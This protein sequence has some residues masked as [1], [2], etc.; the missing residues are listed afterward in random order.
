M[1]KT[2]LTPPS[3]VGGDGLKVVSGVDMPMPLAADDGLY[4]VV[5]PQSPKNLDLPGIDGLGWWASR[6]WRD[7]LVKFDKNNGEPLWAVGRRAPGLAEPGQM[8]CPVSVSGKSGD[9]IFVADALSVVWVWHADGLYIGRLFRDHHAGLSDVPVDQ[10]LYGEIQST[11]VFTDP[12]TGKAY[13]VGAGNEMRIHEL[14]MPA[15]QRLPAVAVTLSAQNAKAARPWDPDGLAP[16][17]KPSIVA[18]PAPGNAPGSF[19]VKVDGEFDGR[20]GWDGW[21]GVPNRPMLVM[22][23]GRSVGTVRAMYDAKNLYLGYSVW[24]ASGPANSGSELPY[25]PF[26]SGAYVDFSIAPDWSQPQRRQV[27]EGDLRVIIARVSNGAA[28]GESIFQQGFWQTKAGGLNPQ[29]ISSPAATVHFDQ[30]TP[31]PGLQAAY[32]I[33]PKDQ[34]SGQIQ[35]TV[36]VIVPLANLGLSDVA[37]KSIG[38]D[39]SIGIANAEGD[40]RERAAHWAGLSEGHV[41]DRPGSAVLLPHT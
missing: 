22:L 24:H 7:K 31:V 39:A 9:A 10:E 13:H 34:R 21:N 35:Y 29:T 33:R 2:V 36:K 38:F 17:E 16:T 27:R 23:D 40:Q 8:Y 20:E 26:V 19:P 15:V 6:N 18:T 11:F 30:I 5:K 28:G 12:G 1:R 41:V 3:F 32:K 4:A 14:I 37:G 25:A